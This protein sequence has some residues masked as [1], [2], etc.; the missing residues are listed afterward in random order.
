MLTFGIILL[1]LVILFFT[2]NGM[3]ITSNPDDLFFGA[4]Y[5]NTE[6]EDGSPAGS[7]IRLGLIIVSVTFYYNAKDN[8][9]Q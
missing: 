7:Y 5:A 8:E 2:S 6:F 4:Q 9:E 3:L 1:A